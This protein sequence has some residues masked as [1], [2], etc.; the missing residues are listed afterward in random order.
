M[1]VITRWYIYIYPIVYFQYISPIKFHY[2]KYIANY[3]PMTWWLFP[4]EYQCP[5]KWTD[6]GPGFF[7]FP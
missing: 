7:Q 1:F 6:H 5:M 4:L 2:M 3:I